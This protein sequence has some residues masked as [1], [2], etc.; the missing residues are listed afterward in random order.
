MS[1]NPTYHRHGSAVFVHRTELCLV[2]SSK[3]AVIDPTEGSDDMKRLMGLFDEAWLGHG[4]EGSIHLAL[5]RF[6]AGESA[7]PPVVTFK[8]GQTVRRMFDGR[9]FTIATN[10]YYNHE[11]ARIHVDPYPFTSDNYELV[12]ES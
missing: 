3:V 11:A 2:T 10:G 5:A 1:E 6:A 12:A 9:R 4:I 7:A 8:P